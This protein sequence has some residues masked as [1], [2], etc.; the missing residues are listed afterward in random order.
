MVEDDDV[1][2]AIEALKIMKFSDCPCPETCRTTNPPGGHMPIAA[3]HFHITDE[4]HL[5]IHRKS[6]IMWHITDLS[7]VDDKNIILASDSQKLPD[8]DRTGNGRF[9]ASLYPVRMPSMS[10][11]VTTLILLHTRYRK[12]YWGYYMV[13]ITYVIEYCTENGA[14]DP[15]SLSGMEKAIMDAITVGDWENKHRL[16]RRME[17]KLGD[18]AVEENKADED[19]F[20]VISDALKP[21]TS[22]ISNPGDAGVED[23]TK[24]ASGSDDEESNKVLKSPEPKQISPSSTIGTADDTATAPAPEK[25]DRNEVHEFPEPKKRDSLSP[26]RIATAGEVGLAEGTNTAPES[27]KHESNREHDSSKPKKRDSL[28]P[29]RGEAPKTA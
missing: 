22:Q 10:C 24:A 5:K 20:P 14:F 21:E 12:I 9:P 2:A 4:E 7:A 29:K 23:D 17:L 18:I 11:F 8:R 13:W 28:S 27:E 15:S 1:D 3:A 16:F 19:M 6:T 25:E 26:K